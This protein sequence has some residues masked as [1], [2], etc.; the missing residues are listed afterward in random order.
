LRILAVAL[1]AITFAKF[2]G[3]AVVV[4]ADHGWRPGVLPWG[5]LIV[6]SGPFAAAALLLRRVARTGA[7]LLLLGS[8]VLA[9]DCVLYVLTQ[10]VP[11][12]GDLLLLIVGGPLAA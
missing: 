11:D 3:I 10:G 7:V 8:T 1:A 4:A 2:A 9:A 5:F 12:G 6:L